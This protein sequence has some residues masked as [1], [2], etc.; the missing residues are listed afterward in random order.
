MALHFQKLTSDKIRFLALVGTR[1]N[2]FLMNLEPVISPTS[3]TGE[4]HQNNAFSF[5]ASLQVRNQYCLNLGIFM[6]RLSCFENLPPILHCILISVSGGLDTRSRERI[7]ASSKAYYTRS[8]KEQTKMTCSK[9][10]S[11]AILPSKCGLRAR[12]GATVN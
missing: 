11:S 9:S 6:S 10:S 1:A 12:S 4:G 8:M 3:P 5:L 2:G 7:K